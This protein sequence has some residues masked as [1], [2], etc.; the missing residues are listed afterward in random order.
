MKRLFLSAAVLPLLHAAP[1]LGQTTIST[2][3][4]APVATSTTGDLTIAIEGSIAP[5]AAGAA[6]TL[7]SANS[8]TNAGKISFNNISDATGILAQAGSSGAIANGGVIELL[9]D[10]TPTD[11]DSDGD[12]DGPFA[13]G[14]RRF[15]IDVAGPFTGSVVNTGAITVEGV[16][17]AAIRIQAPLTG[18]VTHAG[19]IA[20]VG[21]RTHGIMA[22]QVSGDVVST[23]TINVQGDGAVGISL[24]EVGGA[25]KIQNVLSATGYRYPQRLTDEARAKLD[26]DDLKMGGSALRITGSVGGGLL[27]DAPPPDT[28]PDNA[29][30]DGDG[31][32]DSLEA[33]AAVSVA[34]S[35]PAIDLGGA[36]ATGYGAVGAGEYAYGL[37]IRG[38]AAANG[39]NDGVSATAIRVGQEGGGTT[40]LAG[41]INIF[42]GSV[43]AQAYGVDT[44]A[45]GGAATAILLSD[46]ADVPVLRNSGSITATLTGGAQDARA[47][48][49]LSGTLGLVE[50]LG[51]IG[52]LSTPR[53]GS[54]NSGQAI[55]IDLR[56]NTAGATVRQSLA[57][58]TAKPSIVGDILLGSGDDRVEL[59]GGT[60]QGALDFGGGADSL[61]IDNGATASGRIIDADGDLA[62]SIADGRLNIANVTT[63]DLSSLDMGAKGV[64]AV[65]VDPAAGTATR[66]NVSGAANVASGAQFDLTL[67][68]L[69]RETAS[70]EIIKAGSLNLGDVGATLAG[71]PYLY[72]ASLQA[73]VPAGSLSVQL[74]PKTTT[75]L[76]LGGS[77]AQAYSAVFDSLGTNAAIER[78][79]LGA[80]TQE[81][82][83]GLY[84]QML[85]D[86]SGAA[87]MSAQTISSAISQA[88]TRPSLRDVVDDGGM[89]AQE[90]VFRLDHD[91]DQALG[92]RSQGFGF[93]TGVET[94]GQM[95][96]LGLSASFVTADYRDKGAASGEQVAM[97]IFEGGAYWRFEAGGLKADLR[98]GFGYA[99]F[100]SERLLVDAAS[101]LNLKT[102]AK[103]SGWLVDAHAGVSYEARA[104]AFFLRPE[105]SADYLRLSEGDYQE[106]GGGAGFDL[107]VDSRKG[108]LLTGQ[109]ALALGA[110]FGEEMHWSPQI[111]VGYRAKLAGGP[112]STTARFAG[113][114]DFTLNAEDVAAG[115]VVARAGVS[116]G[117]DY[118]L[119]SIDGGGVFGDAYRQYDIH[120][121]VRFRF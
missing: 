18:S 97:N 10:Y 92:F 21:E 110:R 2:A 107:D 48:V 44:A 6:V 3:T 61:V 23:G 62:L 120:A 109:A 51:M 91:R 117:T 11:A 16:D 7:D 121:T 77:G 115:G 22:E 96:A 1:A 31:V 59:L 64:L 28:D 26:D 34:G 93:A 33:T 119:F 55:A 99:R 78:A 20:V 49:D 19:T 73:N 35:A 8:V 9:E 82:F 81:A 14:A 5:A 15:G 104:G 90:I 52:A 24:G 40:S 42:G 69:L 108:D 32:T 39:V 114:S 103:W 38:S 68:S 100:D 95:N 65:A 53:T 113:G 12:L 116:G 58:D 83:T 102:E 98:G 74:R 94:V 50:N 71:A 46:S 57:S 29:D 84:D 111:K 25:V 87:L 75:E 13:Q 41:G 56:A 112:S 67:A 106:S 47:I 76:G 88:I 85:P 45:D 17:S 66:L 43:V 79:F 60:F 70:F 4:T 37:V 89:W 86:H 63:L 101:F 54:S 27:L 72:A 30:E 118:L 105:L 36:A 80:Q